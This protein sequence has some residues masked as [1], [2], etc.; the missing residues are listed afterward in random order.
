[1]NRHN[2]EPVHGSGAA[3]AGMSADVVRDFLCLA[4]GSR[5]GLIGRDGAGR[6][7][8]H[9][10]DRHIVTV[11]GSRAG[12]GSDCEEPG[13]GVLGRVFVQQKHIWLPLL[14]R[15]A[16]MSRSWC[17]NRA[18]TTSRIANKRQSSRSLRKSRGL[19]WGRLRA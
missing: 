3:Y 8:G 7:V 15:S 16:G 10:D 2:R 19:R 9:D 11:A 18:R 13:R 12:K 5:A 14:D 4:N 17:E 1:M 6:Y